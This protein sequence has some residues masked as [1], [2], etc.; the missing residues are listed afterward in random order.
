MNVIAAL[1]IK[2]KIVKIPEVLTRVHVTV[3]TE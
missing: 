2:I 3:D 1:V